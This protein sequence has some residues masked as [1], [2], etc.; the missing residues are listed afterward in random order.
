MS[1]PLLVYTVG[2]RRIVLILSLVALTACGLLPGSARPTASPRSGFT[3]TSTPGGLPRGTPPGNGTPGSTAA[4]GTPPAQASP[5][6]G[7]TLTAAPST[8]GGPVAVRVWLPP[9]FT[10]DVSTGGG[11][12]LADQIQ[13]FETA[14]PGAAVEIRTKA[15]SGTGGLL[16]SLATAA[17][18]A[19]SV[20]PDVIAL[21]RNDLAA[22]TA[23][24]LVA[25]LDGLLPADTLANY[26]PYAQAMARVGGAWV[27]LPFA[28]NARVLAYMNTVYAG[29]PLHWT[30]VVTGPIALP[31]GE[32]SGLTLLDSY[33]A[34]GGT[35]VDA[36]NKLH[37]DSEALAA[38]L[39]AYQHLQ[40]AGLLLPATLDYADPATTWQA[41]R[42]RR[43]VLAVTDSGRFLSEYFRVSGADVTLLPT[44]GEPQL[45]LADGWA[46]AIVNT[47]PE[48]HALAADFIQW[49]SAPAQ[50][51]PWSQA[52]AV[53]PA[54]AD[55]LAAWTQPGLASVVADLETHTQL[56]PTALVL[57]A[58]GPTLQEALLAV[59]NGR[60]TPFAAATVAAAAINQP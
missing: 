11:Q 24:G 3:R 19:P 60:A 33:L 13:A 5:G 59:L 40:T 18:A 57:A 51:G 7:A 20:L 23:A 56:E 37:L 35:L 29:P 45:A 39:Q 4:A 6:L 14:H 48:R 21:S 16:N 10:P 54:R 44:S 32:S 49:L 22:A 53:L 58:I 42:D 28:A 27:G 17:N 8:P 46:W 55:S 25:P 34:A 38:T 30:D 47:A 43:A 15:D 26:Y 41:L 50:N 12:V 9:E 36:N 2:M 1:Y 31:V 52:T